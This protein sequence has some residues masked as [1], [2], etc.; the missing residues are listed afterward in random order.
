[1][2]E[3]GRAAVSLLTLAA[4][5]LLPGDGG[6]LELNRSFITFHDTVS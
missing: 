1:M 2:S 4:T 3:R 6:E 5:I